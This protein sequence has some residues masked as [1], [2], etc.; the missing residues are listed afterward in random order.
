MKFIHAANLK[1]NR[2]PVPDAP[3]ADAVSVREEDFL[4]LL[5]AVQNLAADAL[6][7]TGNLFDHVPT[8][9]ELSALDRLFLPLSARVFILPGE[10]D[11]DEDTEAVRSHIW[12]SHTKVF[13]GDAI[14]R[15][16]VAR[17]ETEITCVGYTKKNY[18]LVS[19]G[20]IMPGARDSMK[21]LLLPFIGESRDALL[22]AEM[23][24]RL[25][26]D[27]AGVGQTLAVAGSAA[28]PLYGPG[29]FEPEDFSG[30]QL[31]GFILG[32]LARGADGAA[33]LSVRMIR[34]AKRE[35]RILKL[36]VR[37]DSDF[38]EVCVSL[39]DRI[40]ESGPENIYRVILDGAVPPALFYRKEELKRFGHI[41]QILDGATEEGLFQAVRTHGAPDLPGRLI[42]LYQKENSGISEKAFRYALEALLHTYDL[43]GVN[44]RRRRE[45]W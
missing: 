41:T 12:K 1:L 18:S 27:Y 13:A 19:S 2:V 28:Y 29:D 21:I 4:K 37:W 3:E 43:V 8:A 40:S 23:P 36:P 45:K 17:W 31:H 44:D 11:A 15:V 34:N 22:T 6:F 24:G 20:R 35:Y 14:D 7:L 42:R 30:Q 9:K 25:P 32:E 33:R 16:Y 38:Q 5:Q 39:S 10:L 26:Y